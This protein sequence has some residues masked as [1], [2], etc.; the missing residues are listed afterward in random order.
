MLDR[1]L[2]PETRIVSRK[3]VPPLPA[4][5]LSVSTHPTCMSWDLDELMPGNAFSSGRRLLHCMAARLNDMVQK[6]Y[7]GG[8]PGAG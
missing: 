5:S 2:D 7:G 1:P 3:T 6:S 4:T 8:K